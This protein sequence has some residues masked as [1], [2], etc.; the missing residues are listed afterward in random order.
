MKS[1]CHEVRRNS[2]SVAAFRPTSACMA[3][4]WRIASSSTVRSSSADSLP[5]A[6]SSRAVSSAAGRSRLPTWSARNGGS[7]A[8]VFLP[9]N[10]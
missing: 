6:W 7:F 1:M 5:F 3:T 9:Q 10:G 8:M 2:P 4:T